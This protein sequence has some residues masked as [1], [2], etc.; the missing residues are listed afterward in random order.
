MLDDSTLLE[1]IDRLLPE[2][3][4]T[5]LAQ[6]LIDEGDLLP[7]DDPRTFANQLWIYVRFAIPW[8]FLRWLMRNAGV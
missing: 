7:N 4:R 6:R 5:A 1:F 8:S 2:A 3:E